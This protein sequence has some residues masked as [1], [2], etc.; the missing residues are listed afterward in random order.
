HGNHA[1][2]PLTGEHQVGDLGLLADLDE[3]VVRDDA[4]QAPHEHRAGAVAAGVQ[5]A[6]PAVC[7]LE[8]KRQSPVGGAVEPRTE[9]HELA[10]ALA[11]SARLRFVTNKLAH[12]SAARRQAVHRPARPEPTITGRAVP[13]TLTRSSR[14]PECYCRTCHAPIG[15]ENRRWGAV[16]A[17]PRSTEGDGP[18]PVRG[19][20]V[21]A[22]LER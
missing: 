1:C 7:G 11:L 4:R 20:D 16:W 3:R 21:D 9:R 6:R 13:A 18:L 15:R 22:P 17:T 14:S 5:N 8:P 10:D 12:P 2:Y 19:A